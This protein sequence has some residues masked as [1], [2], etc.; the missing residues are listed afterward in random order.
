MTFI[1]LYYTA[2]ARRR[3]ADLD[4]R[5]SGASSQTSSRP[6]RS[7]NSTS[8][9]SASI[10]RGFGSQEDRR[11]SLKLTVKAPPSKLREVMRANEVETLKDTL[12]GGQVLDGP[13]SSRRSTL[14]ART[15]VRGAQK[16]KYADFGDSEEDD[17]DAEEDEEE[18]EEEDEEEEVEEEEA[19]ND[20]D[21]LGAEAEGT[22]DE[23][24]D[25]E[26]EDAPAPPPS[27]KTAP[28]KAPKITLKPPAKKVD[29]K[30]SKPKLVVTPANV[31]PVKS[32]EDQEME[33]DPGD[34]EVEEGSSDLS[35][36]DNET[37]ANADD[38]DAEGEEDEI[39]VGETTLQA[40]DEEE[41]DED[42]EEDDSDSLDDSDD[43]PASGSATP[44]LSRMT[45]RQ[46]GRPE[47]QNTLMALD[48]APQ[49]RKF[50]TDEEKAMKKDEHARKRKELT[51]R[52][53]QEEKT[54]ALNR[55]LK[56]QVSKTRGAAPKPE[57]LAAAAAAIGSPYEEDDYV[58]RAH[59]LYTR[60]ISTKDGIK[61]G[62]PE[63]WLGK[64]V[65]K[66]FGPPL[67]PSNGS[68]VQELD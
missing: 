63:V 44:D 46:R 64:N 21:A 66:Y 33:D 56:P 24:E 23:D 13:R 30:Q 59:P 1:T 4:A 9:S 58:T 39:E 3:K 5:S 65:G 32:V 6:R 15:G 60:W 40:E 47:D 52:K 26:M 8:I 35:D 61:L 36:E 48:M 43:M 62:V 2:E 53:V 7:G 14:A 55:L 45:K 19:M 54:A 57:T 42:D 50:F 10:Q 51:K 41:L 18:E 38:E 27:K 29:G 11:H 34:G 25:V 31:G 17:D 16:P 28:P 68:L 49:Q 20:F 67:P 37:P 12:G 22:T